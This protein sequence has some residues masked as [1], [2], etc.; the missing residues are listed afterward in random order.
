MKKIN[1]IV[2]FSKRT[3]TIGESCFGGRQKPNN[4]QVLK[5]VK[6]KQN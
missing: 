2:V 3:F 5:V 6:I 1:R 4:N